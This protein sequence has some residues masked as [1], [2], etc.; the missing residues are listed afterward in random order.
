[1]T[2][3]TNTAILAKL[4]TFSAETAWSGLVEQFEQPLMRYAQRMGLSA[5]TSKEVVQESLLAFA[6][7]YRAGSYDRTKG[8]LSGWL[9]GIARNRVAQA[10]RKA[11]VEPVGRLGTTAAINH[12]DSV[13]DLERAW[14][15]EWRRAIL[16]R[17][18]QRVRTE[19]DPE[20]WECFSMFVLENLGAE[21]VATRLNVPL[22][23]IYNVKHRVS[24]RLRELAL[25]FEDA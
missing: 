7:A 17:C 14:E 3:N 24:R 1:M 16:Q 13:N 9:F 8:R 5:A 6:E 15:E 22:T 25:E 10:R 18:I 21:A 11:A 12:L 20:T 19:I 23:R 4:E 2:W